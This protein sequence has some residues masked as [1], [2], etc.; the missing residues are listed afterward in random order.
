MAV[1]DLSEWIL[2]FEKSKSSLLS[3]EENLMKLFGIYY[4]FFDCSFQMVTCLSGCK[5]GKVNM[6]VTETLFWLFLVANSVAVLSFGYHVF[7]CY[8]LKQNKKRC[9]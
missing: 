9:D 2:T 8:C 5:S 7:M 1:V 6:R 4:S 3:L